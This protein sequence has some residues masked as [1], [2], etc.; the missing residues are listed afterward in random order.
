[1]LSEVTV[2]AELVDGNAFPWSRTRRLYVANG[3]DVAL[4]VTV[5]TPVTVGARALAVADEEFTIPAGEALLLPR[6]GPEFRRSAD[7][8]VWVDYDGPDAAVTVA[9]LDL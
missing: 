1:M 6:L 4:T 2:A 5:Q 8:A 7:G 9:V 3:D